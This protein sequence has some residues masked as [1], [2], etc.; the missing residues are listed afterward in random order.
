MILFY[1][2]H[3]QYRPV[4]FWLIRESKSYLPYLVTLVTYFFDFS[5]IVKV[6]NSLNSAFGFSGDIH[7]DRVPLIFP[8][9]IFTTTG[10]GNIFL[11]YFLHSSFYFSCLPYFPGE[12][13]FS[14]TCDKK[15]FY[16][17]EMF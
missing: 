5:A 11:G 3:S 14:N 7:R 6:F 15:V 16:T 2:I 9:P 13:L 8:T 12:S 17:K 10:P 1:I 4:P